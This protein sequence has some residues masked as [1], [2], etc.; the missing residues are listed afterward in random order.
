M[1]SQKIDKG[2]AKDMGIFALI[3]SGLSVICGSIMLGI[4][5]YTF[6]EN[7]LMDIVIIIGVS[8]L[9]GFYMA[10]VLYFTVKKSK[11]VFTIHLL[12]LLSW[13]LYHLYELVTKGF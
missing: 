4:F 13:V 6:T 2:L 7:I 10:I 1:I 5:G 3:T 12:I 11:Y 8:L 9:T